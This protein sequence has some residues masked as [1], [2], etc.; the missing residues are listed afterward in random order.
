MDAVVGVGDEV[1]GGGDAA[2]SAEGEG[3]G[4]EEVAVSGDGGVAAFFRFLVGD[5]D[6]A[7]TFNGDGEV[8]VGVSAV[9]VEEEKEGTAGD[10]EAFGFFVDEEGAGQGSTEKG[11]GRVCTFDICLANVQMYKPDPIQC[12]EHGGVE[13]GEGVVAEGGVVAE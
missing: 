9:E 10:G 8:G 5:G 3:V 4:V 6:V 12:V 11:W 2:L 7:A 13:F 1:L